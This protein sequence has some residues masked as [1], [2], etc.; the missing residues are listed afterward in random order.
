MENHKINVRLRLIVI[1]NNKILVQ[2][3]Q[4]H[5]FYHYFGGHLEYGETILEGCLRETAEECDGAIF[6][7]KNV[8]GI[9]GGYRFTEA[10][11]GF[12]YFRNR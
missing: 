4:K 5:D 7:F 2:Y 6:D 1:K 9:G 11:L 3:R 12:L 8:F 10:I